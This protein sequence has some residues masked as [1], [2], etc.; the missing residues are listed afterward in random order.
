M[1]TKMVRK[2][3]LQHGC[4]EYEVV[5]LH[6]TT[7]VEVVHTVDDVYDA[8]QHIGNCDKN[9]K[10]GSTKEALIDFCRSAN[11]GDDGITQT[12]RVKNTCSYIYIYPFIS[13]FFCF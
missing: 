6:T 12:T 3:W 2:G 5:A 1:A 10:I 7:V 9:G 4:N 8:R 13:L 11:A